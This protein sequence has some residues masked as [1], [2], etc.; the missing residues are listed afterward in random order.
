MAVSR[1]PA[2]ASKTTAYVHGSQQISEQVSTFSSF[3][4]LSKW[5]SL[6]VAVVLLALT[7]AFQ[8]D[9]SI[10]GGLFAGI[11]LTAVGVLALKSKKSH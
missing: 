4:T 8:P 6:A 1:K 2:A 10:V 7:I 9:G 3:I 11:V 5:G